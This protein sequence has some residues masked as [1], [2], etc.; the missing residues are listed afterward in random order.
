MRNER[1]F[2]LVELLVVVALIAVLAT[3]AIPAFFRE[4]SRAKAESEVAAMFAEFRVRQEAYHLENGVFMSTGATDSATWPTAPL[5]TQ[6]DVYP[7]PAEWTALKMMPSDRRVYCAYVTRSG[8]GDNAAETPGAVATG[9]FG[10]T[11]PTANWFY[12]LA[13]CNMDGDSSVDGW[14]FASSVDTTIQKRTPSR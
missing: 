9:T 7:L 4:S 14:F 3:I 6:Q 11:R 1:G 2:T 5:R 10:F 8:R 12:V 13:R